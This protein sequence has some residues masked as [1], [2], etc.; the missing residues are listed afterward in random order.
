M[1]KIFGQLKP[2]RPRCLRSAVSIAQKDHSCYRCICT[3]FAGEAYVAE[4][5]VQ[6]KRLW[7]QRCH[8]SAC[9][10]RPPDGLGDEMVDTDS[11]RQSR[12]HAPAPPAPQKQAA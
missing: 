1:L 9:P 7:V 2:Q 12:S 4:I 10:D 6:G 11:P 8:Y 5:M 3:I